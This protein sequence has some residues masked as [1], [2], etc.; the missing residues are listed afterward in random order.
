MTSYNN[1]IKSIIQ[2]GGEKFKVFSVGMK[3]AMATFYGVN[4]HN[5]KKVKFTEES[6]YSSSKV[7]GAMSLYNIMQQYFTKKEMMK[8]VVTDGTPNIGSDTIYL[9][10]KFNSV[11]A[12]ELSSDTYKVLVNNI[13]VLQRKNIHVLN[14]DTTVELANMKQDIIFI[15]APWGGRDYKDNK[16]MMLY[17][18]N[19]EISTVYIENKNRA[20]LFIFKVPSNYDIKYF[21][22]ELKKDDPSVKIDTYDY[23]KN[24]RVYYKF[25]AIKNKE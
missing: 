8:M 24:D 23:L 4:K 13:K 20:K 18:S 17:M 9:S 6:I 3:R 16:Y 21:T 12:I 1:Y 22:S 19:K 15:D 11:N 14:G 5:Y 25:I 10:H 2:F 7:K